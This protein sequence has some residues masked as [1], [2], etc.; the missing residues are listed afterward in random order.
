M[1]GR[2]DFFPMA[3]GE[4]GVLAFLIVFSAVAFHPAWRSLELLGM[5]VS[6]WM[7]AALMLVSPLLTL[8]LFASG[9]RGR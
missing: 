6:G 5:A 1:A 8:G 3:R 7:M 2:S 4:R 9:R